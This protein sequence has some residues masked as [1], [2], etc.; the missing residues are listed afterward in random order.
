MRRPGKGCI[1]GTFR[2]ERLGALA[3]FNGV[4]SPGHASEYRP[5]I[6]G[7]R[8]LSIGA[9]VIYHAFPEVLRSGFVGV[10]IFFVISG[11]LIGGLI[12]A[13]LAAGTFR[14]QRFYARRVRRLYPALA[15]VL[16]FTVW[17]G[18][19]VMTPDEFRLLGRHVLAASLFV[20]NFPLMGEIGYFDPEGHSKPLLHLWSLGIEE[21]FYLLWPALAVLTRRSR[22]GFLAMTVVVA[23]VTFVLN[24]ASP[25]PAEAFYA[26]W[27]RFWELTAGVLVAHLPWR[28]SAPA[29]TIACAAGLVMIVVAASIDLPGFPGWW[30]ALP[31]A[32]AALVIASGPDTVPS[33]WL[34]AS[35]PAVFVGKISYPLYL[36]HWPLL[37]FTWIACGA[38][39]SRSLVCAMVAASIVLAWLTYVLVEKPVRFGIRSRWLIAGLVLPVAALGVTGLAILKLDGIPDRRV[40]AD[41]RSLFED[42]RIPLDTRTSDGSCARTYGIDAREPYVCLVNSDRPEMLVIGDS[43]S[44]AFHAAIKSGAVRTPAVLLGTYSTLWAEPGCVTSEPLESWS[45]GNLVCQRALR[46]ALAILDRT[47]SIKAVVVAPFSDNPFFDDPG[48]LRALGAAVLKRGKRLI[49]VAAPP[50][51]YHAPE[52]CRPRHIDVAGIDLTAPSDSQSCR[53]PRSNVERTVRRQHTAFARMAREDPRVELFES[54]PVFCDAEN[55]YQSGDG[56]PYYWSWGHLNNRGSAR[57]L[58]AFLPWLRHVL[59]N[60]L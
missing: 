25:S 12:S 31:V 30:A 37:A 52:G 22:R 38:F 8:A 11:F 18:W 43:V 35:R 57:L 28:A 4:S 10:D 24:V 33:R 56:G 3:T 39:P 7:L 46:D 47:P 27:T 44:M 2:R 21:Q 50:A 26:P 9:V 15:L 60:G 29:R 13:E 53:E 5:D 32:G 59:G 1:N 19:N 17:V 16:G 41:N 34:L 14:F 23:L 20:S 49:L 48:R 45:H 36:W 40:V 54:L 51:F 42:V 6:D 58:E 55:C